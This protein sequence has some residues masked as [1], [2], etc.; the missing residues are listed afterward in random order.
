MW[1]NLKG[2][3]TP[4]N[5]RPRSSA[6]KGCTTPPQVGDKIL[7]SVDEFKYFG[8]LITSDGRWGEWSADGRAAAPKRLEEPDEVV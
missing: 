5:P 1:I 3:D 6:G 2:V 8:V 4:L 7:P